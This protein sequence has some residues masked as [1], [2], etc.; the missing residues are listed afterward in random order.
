MQSPVS[1]SPPYTRLRQRADIQAT[2]RGTRWNSDAFGLQ[3]RKR[4]DV[5]DLD[6][7][8]FGITVTK[9]TA[10]KA[11]ERNRIRRRLREALRT[12]AALPARMSHDYVIVGRRPLLVIPFAELRTNLAGAIADIERRAARRTKDKSDRRDP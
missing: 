3:T 12:G 1:S 2:G 11:V 7:P 6:P 4:P 9:K 8:R 5:M 10:V